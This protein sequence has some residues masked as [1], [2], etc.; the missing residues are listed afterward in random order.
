MAALTILPTGAKDHGVTILQEKDR[1]LHDLGVSQYF[2]DTKEKIQWID[3]QG[4]HAAGLD[5]Y[6]LAPISEREPRKG[7]ETTAVSD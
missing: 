4:V 5:H 3:Y 1:L 6:L 7:T 2:V